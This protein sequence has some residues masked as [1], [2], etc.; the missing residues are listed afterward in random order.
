MKVNGKDYP[1]Y[2]G[3]SKMIET[4][5]QLFS[6]WNRTSFEVTFEPS[7]ISDEH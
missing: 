1:I 3:K 2:Y 5:N 6:K 7:S 4:T